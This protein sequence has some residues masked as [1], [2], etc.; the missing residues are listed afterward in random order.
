MCN[1]VHGNMLSLSSKKERSGKVSLK[2]GIIGI[3][4]KMTI[5]TLMKHFYIA[6]RYFYITNQSISGDISRIIYKS[7]KVVNSNYFTQALQGKLFHTNKMELMN[8]Y[9]IKV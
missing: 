9:F 1:L 7:T 5:N 3:D 4:N 8:V 6:V 2:T